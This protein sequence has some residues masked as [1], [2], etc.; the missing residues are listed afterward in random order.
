TLVIK[1]V[2]RD[3]LID[4]TGSIYCHR[5]PDGYWM[6]GGASNTGADWVS[7]WFR[8]Q[9]LALLNREAEALIPTGLMAWPLLQEGERFPI[10]SPEARGFMPDVDNDILRYAAC[11]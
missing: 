7:K 8:D 5:H 10:L 4:P 11:M 2:T 9:D 3:K 1:G 6:P